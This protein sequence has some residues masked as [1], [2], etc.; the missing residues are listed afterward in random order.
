[1]ERAMRRL[2]TLA[3]LV[4]TLSAPF[5]SA[6][7]QGRF[8]PDSFTNLKVLPRDIPRDTLVNMMAGFTRALGVRCN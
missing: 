3:L 7:A 6:L 2:P 4:A 8:P 5:N 1:M